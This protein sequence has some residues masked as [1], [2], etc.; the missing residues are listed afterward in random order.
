LT[1]M[2]DRGCSGYDDD[3]EADDP[4]KKRIEAFCG[5]NLVLDGDLSDFG[6]AGWLELDASYWKGTEPLGAG[7]LS[8]KL[9]V[10][11]T[12]SGLWVG[13]EVT[14]DVHDNQHQPA[15]LW[16]GDSL[17][18]AFDTGR[19]GG[20]GYDQ[21]DDHEINFALVGEEPRFFRYHGP[22]GA[23]DDFRLA[24][25]RLGTLTRYEI[26]L[27]PFTLPGLSLTA[28]AVSGFSFLVNDADGSGRVGWIE[29]TEGIGTEKAPAYFGEILLDQTCSGPVA[30]GSDAEDAPTD[31]A[32]ASVDG[33]EDEAPGAEEVEKDAGVNSSDDNTEAGEQLNPQLGGNCACSGA[34]PGDVALWVLLGLLMVTFRRRRIF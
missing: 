33:A 28:G 10:R 19:N 15:E 2:R 12:A 24:V 3:N 14:D 1:D 13:A 11:W 5:R 8:V 7:D 20:L 29:W 25:V 18:L 4:P 23:S 34:R 16:Q 22:A 6:S 30:D 31:A 21:T 9:A 32:D 17:Q 26:L 27:P